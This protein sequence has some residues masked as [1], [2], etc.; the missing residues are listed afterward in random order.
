MS[1]FSKWF[2]SA[3]SSRIGRKLAVVVGTL[4]LPSVVLSYLLYGSINVQTEF[5][6][7][8]L[9]G[10]EYMN[11]VRQTAGHAI[12]HRRMVAE[13]LTGYSDNRAQL[14]KRQA[15]IEAAMKAA[16]ALESKLPK[17]QTHTGKVW[18]KIRVDWQK[19]VTL[20]GAAKP[21]G[22]D[23][24]AQALAAYDKY[25]GDLRDLLTEVQ[26]A[27][28]LT[29]DPEYASY[30]LQTSMGSILADSDQIGQV[31]W[32]AMLIA[33]SPTKQ[34]T[35]EEKAAILTL[36]GELKASDGSIDSAIEDII[37]ERKD[38]AAAV[39]AKM[40]A[41]HDVREDFLGCIEKDI[42]KSEK[43]GTTVE[44]VVEESS[45]AVAANLAAFDTASPLLDKEL[46]KRISGFNSTLVTGGVAISIGLLVAIGLAFLITRGFTRQVRAYTDLFAV[47]DKGNYEVR[48]EQ[49]AKDEL[50]DVAVS[51]NQVLA[52]TDTL[53]KKQKAE[54]DALQ[55]S[56]MKLLEDVS[57]AS[58]GDLTREAEVSA[59]ATGA[60]ADSFNFTLEQLRTII[61]RVQAT[62]VQVSTAT[63]EMTAATEHLVSGSEDQAGQ[64]VSVSTAIDQMAATIQKVSENAALSTT[65]ASQALQNAR[66]GNIA[67]RDTIDGMNRIREQT[68]ET[69]KR[70]KRLGETSQEIGQIVQLIDDIADRTGILALNASIQAAAAGDAGRG[71]AVVA[72]EVERLA[73]RSTEATK[74]I[75]ALVRAIQGETTES[76]AA[77]ERNIQE[78]VSGSKVANQAG[79]SLA[80]I[81]GVSVKL[82]DLIQTISTA[83]KQ[84]ARGSEELA[85]SMTGINEI[86][87]QTAA[88]TKQTAESVS[89]LAR[90]ADDLRGSVSTFKLPA[91]MQPVN[92]APTGKAATPA[93]PQTAGRR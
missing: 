57:A 90:L 56:I 85:K 25:I 45:A 26:D 36:L 60:I 46:K 19:V 79:V 66:Q 27:S 48:A 80:E 3:R 82:A 81:E 5:A 44:K 52:T 68:Q 22:T 10:V 76:V 9:A 37:E 62:T 31:G 70:L 4:L 71:F 43:V 20:I 67:V 75:A 16:E 59:D 32:R 17:G 12:E 89:D 1:K 33:A 86:T 54:Y 13:Y 77:M 64:I 21:K 41:R 74:Q 91:H 30:G 15:E 87:Q 35:F 63:T 73:V 7:S 23:K 2:Q 65:V 83:A 8:E 72:E 28:K 14:E 93:K 53:I 58:D 92:A 11:A 88:G 69:A 49:V 6:R 50:G 84:Q 51:I 47:V 55:Q 39:E 42:L 61:A 24:H 78:V 38:I 18:E 40:K 29:L 34:A